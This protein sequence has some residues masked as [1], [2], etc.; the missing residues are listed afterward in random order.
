D[1]R[2]S[3]PAFRDLVPMNYDQ[4]EYI[5]HLEAEVKFCKEELQGLKQRIRVV[6]VENEKLQSELKSRIV[7][8]SLKDY[9]IHN[10]M[11][12]LKVIH[13]AQT[14][15][16]EAQLISLKDLSVS[17]KECEEVKVRLRHKEQQVAEAL[18]ADGAPRVA[19]LCLQCA[20]H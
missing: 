14:E 8:Q 5:Q 4:S 3:L 17:Q 16:L 7:D 2:S 18:K 9:P 19:G 15:S 12:Q 1:G 10:S 6:V 13:Q 20:Q 11:E